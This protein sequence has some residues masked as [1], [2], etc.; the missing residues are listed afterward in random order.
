MARAAIRPQVQRPLGHLDLH[1]HRH[2]HD[3]C[4]HHGLQLQLLQRDV[5]EQ[6]FPFGTQLPHYER[7]VFLGIGGWRVGRVGGAATQHIVPVNRNGHARVGGQHHIRL[8]LG[9][10]RNRPQYSALRR[11]SNKNDV[12]KH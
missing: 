2:D 9:A 7:G 6:P 8:S 5:A 10:R 1:H 11:K 12:V 4:G 3:Q